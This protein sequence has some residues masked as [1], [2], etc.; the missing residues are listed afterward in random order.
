MSKGDNDIKSKLSKTS[1]KNKIMK[2]E[3]YNFEDILA[4]LE[5]PGISAID[6]QLPLPDLQNLQYEDVSTINQRVDLI[7][8]E[9]TTG[10][11]RDQEFSDLY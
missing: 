11:K 1:K 4:G 7:K 2:D 8:R 6:F 3:E 9:K 5:M 10:N